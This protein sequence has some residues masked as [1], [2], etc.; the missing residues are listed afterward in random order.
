MAEKPDWRSLTA[1]LSDSEQTLQNQ[2]RSTVLGLRWNSPQ[3]PQETSWSELLHRSQT[4][5]SFNETR[6]SWTEGET[7]M[8]SK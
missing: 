8:A 7:F 2:K 5:W 6:G 4:R 1:S 3:P